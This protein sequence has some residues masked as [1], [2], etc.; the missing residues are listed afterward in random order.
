MIPTFSPLPDPQELRLNSDVDSVV[1]SADALVAAAS[2]LERECAHSTVGLFAGVKTRP[3]PRQSNS[4]RIDPDDAGDGVETP[5]GIAAA[6][7]EGA[8]SD[9]A[10]DAATLLLPSLPWLLLAPPKRRPDSP[11]WGPCRAADAGPLPPPPHT[12]GPSARR[13][14]EAGRWFTASSP[15]SSEGLGAAG[16]PHDRLVPLVSAS[17]S[18]EVTMAGVVV[19]AAALAGLEAA[20]RCKDTVSAART[21]SST[22]P[23]SP[24]DAPLML[25]LVLL[26]PPRSGVLL[27]PADTPP[28]RLLFPTTA[29]LLPPIEAPL[30]VQL[31]GKRLSRLL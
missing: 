11:L 20:E 2:S 23:L 24:K 27:L 26:L 9:H 4:R 16:E 18:V 28:L 13:V 5:A 15:L 29:R 1:P 19:V 17:T 30:C 6:A 31:L 25:V 14:E 12:C 3:A 21:A 10:P 22:L 7:A 8:A